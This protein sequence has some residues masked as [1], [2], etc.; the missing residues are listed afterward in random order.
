M[1]IY[2]YVYICIHITTN[3]DIQTNLYQLFTQSPKV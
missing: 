3:K 2:I 1:H